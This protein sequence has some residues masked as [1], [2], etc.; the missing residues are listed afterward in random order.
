M[1]FELGN[2][3]RIVVPRHIGKFTIVIIILTIRLRAVRI[4][5]SHIYIPALCGAFSSAPATA[6]CP[7]GTT[8]SPACRYFWRISSAQLRPL[9]LQSSDKSAFLGALLATW[10][11]CHT[12]TGGRNPCAP[13]LN[14]LGW[15][16]SWRLGI[17][18]IPTVVVETNM[19]VPTKFVPNDVVFDF[20]QAKTLW[21]F[22]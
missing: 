14:D 13:L 19:A 8:S 20:P 16:T 5:G 17:V 4:L 22:L 3:S 15:A 10:F 7:E 2:T 1:F 11:L 12:T 6:M 9:S 21:L 18:V